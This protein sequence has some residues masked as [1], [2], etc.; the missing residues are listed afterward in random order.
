MKLRRHTHDLSYTN[1]LTAK[2]GILVPCGHTE[3]LPGD[4]FNMK[5]S[6][7]IRVQPLNKPLMHEVECRV[8]H[9]FV[10]NRILWGGWEDFITGVTDH[11]TTPIPVQVPQSLPNFEIYEHCGGATGVVGMAFHSFINQG[12]NKIWNEFYRDQEVQTELSEAQIA[13][14]GTLQNICWNKDY[15]TTARKSPQL[16]SSVQIPIGL[17]GLIPVR[18]IGWA[19]GDSLPTATPTSV[20]NFLDSAFEAANKTDDGRQAWVYSDQ[21]NPSLGPRLQLEAQQAAGTSRTPKAPRIYADTSSTG[22]GININVLRGAMASQRIAEARALFGTRYTDYLAYYGV[23]SSDARLQRP[24]YLGGWSKR[25]NFSEVLTTDTGTTGAGQLYGHGIAHKS[26]GRFRKMFEEHGTLWS[27]LSIRPLAVYQQG[28]PRKFSRR[29]PL[30]YWSR[31]FENTPWQSIQQSEIYS[32]VANSR[33]ANPSDPTWGYTSRFDEYRESHNIIS[34]D[35]RQ[36]AAASPD[37]ADYHW[38]RYFDSAISSV[39]PT[40]VK[41]DPN[42]R[43]FQDTSGP[44]FLIHMTHDIKAKRL[45]S[46]NAVIQHAL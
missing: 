16:G 35:M 42:A 44:Q 38:A 3:I 23:K 24:E 21:T 28:K 1:T 36:D 19:G 4:T 15:F 22:S 45:V 9:W 37:I 7:L 40:F 32:T 25:I 20:D 34:S 6:A 43:I 30:D 26:G 29:S 2:A 31:E 12:Y 11:V 5:T 39:D 46:K 8:H 18:G 33:H 41:C 13:S 14:S 17:D 27:L 10:P